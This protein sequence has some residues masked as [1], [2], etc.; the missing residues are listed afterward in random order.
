MQSLE[1]LDTMENCEYLKHAFCKGSAVLCR[2]LEKP[3]DRE[4]NGNINKLNCVYKDRKRERWK[5]AKKEQKE[6]LNI[7]K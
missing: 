6:M 5:S 3:K 4:M 2:E 1:N 7:L